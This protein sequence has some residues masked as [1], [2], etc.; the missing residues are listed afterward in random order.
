VWL[1]ARQLLADRCVL[2]AAAG[3][4]K[5]PISFGCPLKPRD[6]CQSYLVTRSVLSYE[7]TG[8]W[9]LAKQFIG[10]MDDECGLV[11]LV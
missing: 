11:L 6:S 9:L 3:K 5:G 2:V 1:H 7:L 10:V 4:P 8:P